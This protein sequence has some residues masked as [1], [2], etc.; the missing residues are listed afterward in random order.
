M[1][2]KVKNLRAW[3]MKWAETKWGA[4]GLFSCAFADASFIGVPTPMFFFAVSILNLSKAYKYALY[5]TLGILLGS[6]AGYTIGH[7]AW[8]NSHGDF[9]GLANAAFKYIPGFSQD[10]YN[11]INAVLG[12]W[13]FLVLLISSFVPVPFMIFSVSS[14]VFD[15]N[16]LMFC[17][18]IFVGQGLRFY[19][20]AFL[21]VKLGPGFKKLFRYNFKTAAIFSAVSITAAIVLIKVIL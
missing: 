15:I 12:K 8:L 11:N 16:F 21:I 17:L 2:E 10:S 14:G 19:L 20:M 13:D 18:A 3:V 7:F 1:R 9:S 6:I 4:W 5:G